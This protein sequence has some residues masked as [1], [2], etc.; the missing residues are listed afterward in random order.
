[1]C[2]DKRIKVCL[3]T[4]DF[5]MGFLLLWNF[6]RVM[7]NLLQGLSGVAMYLDDILMTGAMQKEHLSTL[8]KVLGQLETWGLRLK[9]K[10]SVHGSFCNL[11][12]TPD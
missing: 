2:G 1:M 5:H 9:N 12:W 3:N 7:D 10:M 8:E 11:P 4:Q 6:Q